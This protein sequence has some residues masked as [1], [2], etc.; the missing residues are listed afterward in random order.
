MP[1]KTELMSAQGGFWQRMQR[2]FVD[3]RNGTSEKEEV[4]FE[5]HGK[6][7]RYVHAAYFLNKY[8]KYDNSFPETMAWVKRKI[9][10]GLLRTTVICLCGSRSRKNIVPLGDMRDIV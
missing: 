3:V 2:A 5:N 10:F 6:R 1:T 9:R 7:A 8:E 4:Q